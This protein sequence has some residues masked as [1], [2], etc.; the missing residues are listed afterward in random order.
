LRRFF[1]GRILMRVCIAAQYLSAGSGGIARV[2]RLTAQVAHDVGYEV[3]ALAAADIQP[4]TDL[5]MP[6]RYYGGN[7]LK[8]VLAA[9]REALQCR[10]FIYDFAGT[11]RAHMPVRDL[12]RPYAVW[13]CGIEVWEQLRP[14]HRRVIEGATKIFAI[15][16][17]TKARA[18]SLHGC[19]DRS[20]VCWIATF[21]DKPALRTTPPQGHPPTVLIMSRLAEDRY[22]GHEPLVAIWPAVVSKIK[23]ARLVM[24]GGGQRLS[25][26]RDLVAAS[27]AAANIDILGFVPEAQ[28][29]ALWQRANVFAMP[30]L[31]EGFGLVYIEAMRHGL[32]VIGS[33]HDAAPEVNID[34]ETGYNVAIQ[35]LDDLTDRVIALLS[36]PDHAQRL[37]AAGQA[38]WA[39]HFSYSQF[40]T[41]FGPMLDGLTGRR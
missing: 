28:L 40:K 26:M 23:D 15:S 2:A 8:F 5:A 37:G 38:R 36:D 4:V 7:R 18:Q 35:R 29:E 10:H 32:P 27:P 22:K 25:E 34:G 1:Q 19:F 21:E 16:D 11:G 20:E 13:I 3:S 24:V 12:S 41:R 17:Y 6:V 9:Q 39:Q 30:S 31:G 33:V 14:S